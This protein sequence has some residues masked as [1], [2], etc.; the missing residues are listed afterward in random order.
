MRL[1]G[2]A[3][4]GN[5]MRNGASA[6]PHGAR[7]STPYS[8]NS[9]LLNLI[10]RPELSPANQG[11]MY[12][13]HSPARALPKLTSRQTL[14]GH[15]SLSRPPETVCSKQ[16]YCDPRK[17]WW[18]RQVSN[19]RPLVCKTRA[20]PLSYTPRCRCRLPATAPLPQNPAPSVNPH[21]GQRCSPGRLIA[22]LA[23]L[24][25]LR[26]ADHPTPINDERPAVGDSGIFVEHPV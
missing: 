7:W 22:R 11:Q 1:A 16:S 5:D 26:E 17:P 15:W 18:A 6:R 3:L 13:Y 21:R 8:T 24:L 20:L 25:A 19:L 23:G 9:R 2:A 4:V 10:Q 12:T 14:K